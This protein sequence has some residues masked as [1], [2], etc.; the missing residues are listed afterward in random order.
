MLGD[1]F[2]STLAL[3]NLRR[4][5]EVAQMVIQKAEKLCVEYDVKVEGRTENG[6]PRD[7]ICEMV[8]ALG[9][10]L[11]VMGSHGYGPITRTILGSVSNHCVQSASCPVLVV[12]MPKTT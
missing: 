8:K 11:L 9:A 4:D 10:D 3:M 12:K 5:G 7:V 1:P 2:L 6:D